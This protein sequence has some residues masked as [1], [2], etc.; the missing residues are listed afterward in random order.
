MRYAS[1]GCFYVR[2]LSAA[3][4]AAL[5]GPAAA[6]SQ[7]QNPI[8]SL[9]NIW[10]KNAP[11]QPQPANGQPN[12]PQANKPG[13]AAAKGSVND[14]GPFT[15]QPGTKI[16]PVVMAPIE[17]GAA[18]AVSPHEPR[19]PARGSSLYQCQPAAVGVH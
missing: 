12:S 17:Q 19:R 2:L 18:F 7:N 1:R 15:P 16:D 10:N 11:A 9:K 3:L 5:A 13:Q 4:M 14:N 6:Q 8:Q